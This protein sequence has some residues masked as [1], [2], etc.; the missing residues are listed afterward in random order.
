M[1]HFIIPDSVTISKGAKTVASYL[2][3]YFLLFG[4]GETEAHLHADNCVEQIKNH[5]I[6]YYLAWRVIMGLAKEISNSSL[7]QGHTKFSADWGF[8]IAKTN[9]KQ[10]NV[11]TIKKLSEMI[12]SSSFVNKSFNKSNKK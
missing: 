6:L 3:V 12:E 9:T 4:L 2:H 5:V 1:I 11:V 10:R 7:P 8:G